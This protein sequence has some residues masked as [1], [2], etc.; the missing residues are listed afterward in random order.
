MGK[1]F[2]VRMREVPYQQ[3]FQEKKISYTG[4]FL[5]FQYKKKKKKK[6]QP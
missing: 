4:Q 6:V 1:N 5:T 3:C 2:L